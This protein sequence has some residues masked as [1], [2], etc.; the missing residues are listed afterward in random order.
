MRHPIDWEVDTQRLFGLN[1]TVQGS[2]GEAYATLTRGKEIPPFLLKYE[3]DF[4]DRSDRYDA[5][6]RSR[7]ARCVEAVNSI[8][9]N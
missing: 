6:T 1:C 7:R 8:F 2:V 4:V 5:A 3:G 9:T